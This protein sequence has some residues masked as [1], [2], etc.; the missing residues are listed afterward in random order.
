MASTLAQAFAA[1]AAASGEHPFLI[2]PARADRDWHPA[3][4]ELSY[5]AVAGEAM[6]LRALYAAADMGSATAWRCCWRAGRSSFSTTW[7]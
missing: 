2:V 7:R 1:T 4:L 5:A 6:R 3:G